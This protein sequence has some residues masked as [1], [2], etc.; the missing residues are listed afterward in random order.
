MHT[1]ACTG[2]EGVWWR[3]NDA[4]EAMEDGDG[5]PRLQLHLVMLDDAAFPVA[6]LGE[7][8]AGPQKVRYALVY[9]NP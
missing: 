3:H 8:K 1:R 9:V 6:N 7:S 4:A 5:A 2:N